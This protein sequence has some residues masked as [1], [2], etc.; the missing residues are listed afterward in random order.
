MGITVSL[1]HCI[2][3]EIYNYNGIIVIQD[4]QTGKTYDVFTLGQ[5][6]HSVMVMNEI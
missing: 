3:T 5:F 2:A 4:A 6:Q 1:L